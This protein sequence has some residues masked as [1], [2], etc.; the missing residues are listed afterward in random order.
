MSAGTP[1]SGRALVRAGSKP[2]AAAEACAPALDNSFRIRIDYS[3]SA[4][5]AGRWHCWVG[6]RADSAESCRA[7]S[8]L[9]FVGCRSLVRVCPGSEAHRREEQVGLACNP[10]HIVIS[11]AIRIKTDYITDSARPAYASWLAEA[12]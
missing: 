2:V 1:A 10:G 8:P 12:S 9:L 4:S 11:E 7:A 5:R 6:R 3:N